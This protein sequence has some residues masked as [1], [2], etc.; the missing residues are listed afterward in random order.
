MQ[1]FKSALL[2]G[3]AC[4]IAAPGF[5]ADLSRPVPYTKAPI[6]EPVSAYN[7]SGF[8]LGGN[9]GGKWGSYDS[10]ITTGTGQVLGF[11]G[12][13]D[14]SFVGGGQ[15][16]FMWQTGQF[17]FGVEGD[18]DATRLHKDFVAVTGVPAPFVAGDSL[19]LRNDWQASARGRLGWAFDRTLL[20]VTGGG[21]WANIKATATFV[22]VP[23]IAGA[24]VSGDRTVF[25]W[26][27]GGGFDYG[28]APGWSLGVEYRFTRYENDNNGNSFGLLTTTTAG[29]TTPLTVSRSLDT[30]ELTARVN[31]HF[32][33][34][35]PVA[36]R[37]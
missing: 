26:T 21:S 5:A 6:A 9:L 20:Y 34:A 27:L 28:I 19:A 7:W 32:N 11:S 3:V 30:N 25:G 15:A 33:W 37:Y 16:G 1:L 23:G 12:H 22:P 36:A 8:Y 17:V 24:T 35:G 2:A 29:L 14:A 31:Y 18:I 13:G 10:T 4:A